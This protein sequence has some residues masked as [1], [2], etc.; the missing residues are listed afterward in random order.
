MTWLHVAPSKAGVET[1]GACAVNWPGQLESAV[2]PWFRIPLTCSM[3][4]MTSKS[5]M[6]ATLLII[7]ST[8]RTKQLNVVLTSRK[9]TSRLFSLRPLWSA[10]TMHKYIGSNPG[11]ETWVINL[12]HW[13]RDR[14]LAALNI[15]DEACS[16]YGIRWHVFVVPGCKRL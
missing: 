14:G 4:L 5:Q 1:S 10:L 15:M 16:K 8:R 3:S 11:E 9:P 2:D 13:A 7:R 6:A 12:T